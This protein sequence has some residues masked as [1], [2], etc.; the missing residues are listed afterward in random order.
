MNYPPQYSPYPSIGMGG[1]GMTAQ[2]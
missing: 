1:M 2:S